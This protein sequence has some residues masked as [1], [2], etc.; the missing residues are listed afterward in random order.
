M[1]D[2]KINPNEYI[3]QLNIVFKS[4]NDLYEKY[5]H[6]KGSKIPKQILTVMAIEVDKLD[7]K[8]KY[9]FSEKLC[10]K[11]KSIYFLKTLSDINER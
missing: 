6:Y 10:G 3:K 7:N 9:C 11:R 5:K 1:I 4:A 2:F 8:N